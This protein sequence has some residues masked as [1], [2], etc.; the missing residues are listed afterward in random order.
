MKA[1]RMGCSAGLLCQSRLA[2]MGQK[3]ADVFWLWAHPAASQHVG[4]F[5]GSLLAYDAWAQPEK[6]R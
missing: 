5:A 3:I 2:G 6:H 4:M 1:F